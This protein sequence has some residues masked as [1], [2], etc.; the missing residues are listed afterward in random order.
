VK[1]NDLNDMDVVI[2]SL[3][4]NDD[5]DDHVDRLYLGALQD[6]G[7]LSPLSAWTDEPAFGDSIEFLVDEVDRFSLTR[8]TEEQRNNDENNNNNNNNNE[9]KTNII[10]IHHLLSEAEVSYSARQCPR[11]VHNP[12]GEESERLY[13]VDQ[14]L[15]D[16]FRVTMKIKPELEILW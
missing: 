6:D 1:I 11:G 8:E 3:V 15:I 10:R 13:Y 2:Y 16:Q 12:H 7:S 5:D 4:D 9:N 14:E